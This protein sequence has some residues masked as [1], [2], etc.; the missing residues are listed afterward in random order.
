MDHDPLQPPAATRTF[1][2][3]VAITAACLAAFY[4]AAAYLIAPFAWK[5]YVHKHPALDNVPGITETKTGIPG[6]PL[7]VG[8]IGTREQ[9]VQIMTAANW[10]EAKPLSLHSDLKI[11]EA[12]VLERPDAQAP[13][14]SLYL[15]GRKE[16]LAFEQQVGHDPRQRHHV[17]FWK[18]T[19]EDSGR[20]VWVGSAVFD[21]RV[22][23]SHTT[24]QITH[25][26]A[27]NV[28]AERDKLFRDL[29][30]TGELAEQYVVP[31]FHKVR[32]GRNGGGDPWTTDGSLYMGVIKPDAGS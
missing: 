20:P 19:E 30:Q 8:L 26:T 12:T 15:F 32:H 2:Q 11:A 3:R 17:R 6:D 7:N 22:G 1:W 10:P 21:R 29:T 23:F 16:D 4:F 28:D 18:T 9:V 27:P 31:D 25:H 5:R 13:V 24:G 14:S